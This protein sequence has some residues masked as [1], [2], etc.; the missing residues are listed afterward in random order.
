MSITIYP[1]VKKIKIKKSK[2]QVDDTHFIP[3]VLSYSNNVYKNGFGNSINTFNSIDISRPISLLGL[4][5][6]Y[7]FHYNPR[8]SI[9]VYYKYNQIIPRTIYIND[10]V[11]KQINGF[12]YSMDFSFFRFFKKSKF[13][14]LN[15]C[16]GFSTGRLRITSSDVKQKNPFFAPSLS[17]HNSYRIKKFCIQWGASYSFDVS[18]TGWRKTYFSNESGM[19]IQPFNQTGVNVS[20]GIGYSINRIFQ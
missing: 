18:K 9:H 2:T 6:H 7:F 12:N 4:E 20:V 16:V 11:K 14:K 17:I 3:L 8:N 1:Q 5:L 15:L 10:S 19:L 13:T